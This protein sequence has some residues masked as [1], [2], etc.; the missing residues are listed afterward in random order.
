MSTI[1]IKEAIHRKIE[2]L[3]NVGELIDINQSLDWYLVD[4][5]S[6]E[7]KM[8]LDRMVSLMPTLEEG[9]GLKHE[10]VQTAMKAWIRK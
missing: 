1:E 10:D 6:V 2:A 7:E 3:E 9:K 8:V 4:K 5:L